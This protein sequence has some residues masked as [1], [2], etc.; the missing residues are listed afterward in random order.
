MHLL[1][2]LS[3]AH[4]AERCAPSIEMPLKCR[5]RAILRTCCYRHMQPWRKVLCLRH[6]VLLAAQRSPRACPDDSEW[7]ERGPNAEALS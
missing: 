4:C 3:L 6:R 5:S 7:D 2:Q 1:N